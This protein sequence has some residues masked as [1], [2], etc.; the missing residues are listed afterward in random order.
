MASQGPFGCADNWQEDTSVGSVSWI[1]PNGALSGEGGLTLSTASSGTSHR[2]QTLAGFHGFTIP[3]GSTINGIFSEFR[4]KDSC[5]VEGTL[6]RLSDGHDAS[7]EKLEVGDE[8]IGFK[9]DLTT[10]PVKVLTIS[11]IPA[12]EY[13][14]ITTTKRMPDLYGLHRDESKFVDRQTIRAT[15]THPFFT[16]AMK[17]V[18]ARDLVVGDRLYTSYTRADYKSDSSVF[19][20]YGLEIITSIFIVQEFVTVYDITV[21]APN[22]FI[23]N[24][25]W[26]H[27]KGAALTQ[28]VS[29]VV[30]KAGTPVGSDRVAGQEWSTTFSYLG[31]GGPDDLFDTTWT[32][33]EINNDLGIGWAG[34]QS[35]NTI[36]MD[37][38]R[39]TVYY[40]AAAGGILQQQRI[41]RQAVKR[42][43][44]W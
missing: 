21:D 11:K 29:A 20:Q 38:A 25:F 12:K 28:D 37:Y 22:T 6:V 17:F 10:V 4:V 27:N 36:V 5:L 42:A 15:G 9:D 43:S 33:N 35:A 14:I 24:N 34:N 31:Y 8:L 19:Q 16:D 1:N 30:Y 23:A 32:V 26:V 13:Y 41:M 18:P 39:A 3:V 40:T 2:I 44:S 7:I